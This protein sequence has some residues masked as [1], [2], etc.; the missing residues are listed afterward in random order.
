MSEIVFKR[1]MNI[2][3]ISAESDNEFLE[4]CF[5]AT[6]EFEELCDFQR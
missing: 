2:G 1:S 5:L 3:T 6:P 4:N